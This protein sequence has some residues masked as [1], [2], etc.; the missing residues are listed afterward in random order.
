MLETRPI[1]GV[2]VV[3][4]LRYEPPWLALLAEDRVEARNEP[5]SRERLHARWRAGRVAAVIG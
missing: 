1:G 5:A 4:E 3:P 2:P